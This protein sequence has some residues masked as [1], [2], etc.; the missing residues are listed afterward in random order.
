MKKEMVYSRLSFSLYFNLRCVVI[1]FLIQ[2]GPATPAP[3]STPTPSTP[4]TPATGEP[5]KKRG[6]PP[7]AAVTDTVRIQ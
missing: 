3:E 4:I 5:A 6:R 7:T 2:S 1:N